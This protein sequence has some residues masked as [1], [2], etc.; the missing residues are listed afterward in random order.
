[1]TLRRIRIQQWLVPLSGILFCLFI[2][3]VLIRFGFIRSLFLPPPTAILFA[4][5]KNFGYLISSAA[6]TVRDIAVGYVAG[7]AVG[8]AFGI[9]I[10]YYR[11]L[12]LAISPLLLIISPI[13]IVTFMPL[14]II[15]FGLNILPVIACA[16]IAAFFP[17]LLNTI[18]GV[19]NVDYRWIEVAKN[20]GATNYQI[21]QKIIIPAALPHIADGLRLSIQICF[22]ITPVAEMIMGQVGLGG[23]IWRSAD[24]FKTDLVILGQLTLG[25]M[26]LFLYRVFG[27]VESHILL[28]WRPVKA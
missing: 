10:G 20:L 2:W 22:L 6:V 1:M 19:R 13:P 18:S 14:F 9:L 24:L 3:E 16:F 8:I 27:W 5:T 28:P 21:L 17:C 25:V 7:C 12:N 4:L 26:G 15:W 11:L 23:F